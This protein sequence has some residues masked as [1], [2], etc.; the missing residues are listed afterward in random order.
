MRRMAEGFFPSLEWIYPS[1]F[2]CTQGDSVL[3]VLKPE[4]APSVETE[5]VSLLAN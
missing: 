5:L 1:I 4:K 3:G 2:H